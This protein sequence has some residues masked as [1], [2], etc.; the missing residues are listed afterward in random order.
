MLM[1]PNRG[2]GIVVLTNGVNGALL[3]EITRTFKNEYRLAPGRAQ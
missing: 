3:D 1:F 2:R